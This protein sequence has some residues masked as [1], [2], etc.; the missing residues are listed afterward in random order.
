VY[1]RVS[2]SDYQCSV[3]RWYLGVVRRLY[4][5]VARRWLSQS[6]KALILMYGRQTGYSLSAEHLHCWY[7][8]HF[9]TTETD[10]HGYTTYCRAFSFI[11]WCRLTSDIDMTI[12]TVRLSV[13]F[14]VAAAPVVV[15][16]EDQDRRPGLSDVNVFSFS[17]R[18]HVE[19]N[20]RNTSCPSGRRQA[21]PLSWIRSCC[22]CFPAPVNAIINL[23]ATPTTHRLLVRNLL[24]VKSLY[25]HRVRKKR[26]HTQTKCC[27]M[28]SI[29]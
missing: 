6:L 14:N 23:E 5:I 15:R 3:R 24:P 9:R 20:T 16:W 26:P 7:A 1:S 18:T 27:N 21:S 12:L 10:T 25:I 17:H 13:P 4:I 8:P 19:G 28:H 2:E 11:H 29:V 22:C